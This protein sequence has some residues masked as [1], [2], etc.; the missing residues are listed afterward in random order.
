LSH[1]LKNRLVLVVLALIGLISAVAC[2]GESD[3]A[4]FT[5]MKKNKQVIVGT[6]AVNLPFE[7]GKGMGVQGYDVDIA[8]DICKEIGYDPNWIKLSFERLFPSLQNREV[9]FVISAI[10]ITDERKKEFAFSKPY[11]ESGQIVAIRREME[12]VKTLKDIEGFK[13]G[14]QEGTT[15]DT[16]LTTSGRISKFERKPYATLDDALL[17]LNNREIDAVI[18]DYPIIS[19]SIFQSFTNLKTIGDKLTKEQY[20]IVVRKEDTELLKIINKVLDQIKSSGKDKQLYTQWFSDVEKGIAEQKKKEADLERWMTTP[21]T[22]VFRF[23]RDPSFK[24]KMSRL[25]GF[26]VQLKHKESGQV[27]TSTAIETQG[28]TG[29]CRISVIPGTYQFSMKGYQLSGEIEVPLI[30][31]MNLTSNVRLAA[32]ASIGQPK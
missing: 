7:F 32:L 9:D 24:F 13:I 18:G 21:K 12:K 1:F 20:G 27:F 2:S 23:E 6:D 8:V 10:T 4:T 29:S 14:V 5:K 15:G 19:Y 28:D 17:A 3:N 16:Y 30:E 31:S 11:F 26:N 25:D 22:I